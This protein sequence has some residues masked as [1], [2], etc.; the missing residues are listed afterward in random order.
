MC[1]SPRAT[2]GYGRASPTRGHARQCSTRAGVS[3]LTAGAASRLSQLASRCRGGESLYPWIL[4]LRRQ[5]AALL[6]FRTRPAAVNH[7]SPPSFLPLRHPRCRAPAADPLPS[8]TLIRLLLLARR[9]QSPSTC[10]PSW[11][12]AP[13]GLRSAVAATLRTPRR[14]RFSPPFFL[15]PCLPRC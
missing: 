15:S 4:C 9:L 2:A 11:N 13:M 1:A 10:G 8:Y 7:L 12:G 3:A 5:C 14:P 6:D